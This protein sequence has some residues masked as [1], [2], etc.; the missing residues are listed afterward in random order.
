MFKPFSLF[1]GVRYA[2]KIRQ[3]TKFISFISSTSVVGLAL[4]VAVLIIVMSVMNG[5]DRELKHKILGMVPHASIHPINNTNLDYNFIDQAKQHPQ[6]E[7]VA[8]FLEAQGLLTSGTEVNG[9]LVYGVDPNLENSV[10]IISNY[11]QLGSL[12]SLSEGSFNLVLGEMLAIKLGVGIGDKITLLLPEAAISLAGVFPRLRRFTVTGVFAIGADIDSH[13]AYV[14]IKDLA[15]FLRIDQKSVSFRLKI[16][17]LFLADNTARQ[18]KHNLPG[19]YEVRSWFQTHG[20]LFNAIQIEKKMIALLLLLIIAVAAFNIVST[21][22]MVVTNKQSDI[23]ILRT[24][25][26]GQQDILNIF[27]IQGALIGF[28]GTLIGLIFGVLGAWYI[29]DIVRFIENLSGVNFLNPDV[30][31]ISQLPSQIQYLDI[32]YIAIAGFTMSVVAAVYPAW[33]ASKIQPAEALRYE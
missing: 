16:K 8:P 15:N 11:M 24:F 6:V 27:I 1:L 14:N 18:I 29:S 20:T 13:L 3:K 5:F 21:L 28:V 31:F 30:Y 23:A 32:I 19:E 17:N 22:M 2:T 4:G 25:G 33:R 9:V 26:A 7:A 10:S 12:S